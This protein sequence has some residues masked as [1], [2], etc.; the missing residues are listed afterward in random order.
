MLGWSLKIP[1]GS[2]EDLGHG[3]DGCGKGVLVCR[4][5]KNKW[6]SEIY[7]ICY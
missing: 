6:I 4:S 7:L 5:Q 3:N 1:V 2:F